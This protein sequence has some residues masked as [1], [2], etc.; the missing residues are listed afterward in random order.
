MNHDF[1][2][3]ARIVLPAQL[4]DAGQRPIGNDEFIRVVDVQRRYLG[5][6]MSRRWWYRQIELGR[7]PHL[8]AGGAVLLR[9]ADIE[10]FIRENFR[11]KAKPNSASEDSLPTQTPAPTPKKRAS[12]FPN[13]TLPGGLRF[14]KR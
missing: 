1:Q 7:L 2:N 5:G 6:T 9:P 10:A 4:C 8:R 3:T 11:E 13:G 12:S 14:F